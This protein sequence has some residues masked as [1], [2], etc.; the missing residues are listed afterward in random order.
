MGMP[1]QDIGDA[2]QLNR[3]RD[4]HSSERLLERLKQYH[5]EL[6]QEDNIEPEPLP[7]IPDSEIQRAS[8]LI[9]GFDAGFNR[10]TTIQRAVL[11]FY[12]GS[13]L[14]D[15]KGPGR[16]KQIVRP[17]QLAMY[18]AKMLTDAGF[19]KIGRHFGMRDHSTALHAVRKI[20]TL[21][22]IDN[23]LAAQIAAITESLGGAIA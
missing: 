6:P 4:K 9:H 19:L 1:R 20:S 17:R 18:L 10:I 8:E 3:A 23:E 15:L 22:K 14:D 12:P 16:T 11:T 7:S 2:E 21:A 13:T 5:G